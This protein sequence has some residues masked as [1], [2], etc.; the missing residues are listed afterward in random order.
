MLIYRVEKY[1]LQTKYVRPLQTI[2]VWTLITLHSKGII[3]KSHTVGI[4][5]IYFRT[6]AVF[7]I[8]LKV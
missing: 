5:S 6:I 3:T 1:R 4:Q 2:D 8:L 7:K